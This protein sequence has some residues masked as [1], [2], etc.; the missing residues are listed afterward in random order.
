[1]RRWAIGLLASGLVVLA[2]AYVAHMW[3]RAAPADAPRIEVEIEPGDTL[4]R[5]AARLERAGVVSSGARFRLLA[6]LLG[7]ARP[8]QPGLYEF[9]AGEGWGRVLEKLQRGDVLVLR[10]VIPEGLPS[11]LVHERLMAAPR[12]VGEVEVPPEGSV[13]P[14]TWDYRP[15]ETRAAVLRRMQQGMERTLAELWAKRSPATPVKTPHEAV[16]LASIVEKETARPE[17]RRR[18]AGL[19]ANRLKAGMRLEADPTVIYP[20]TQGRPL[21]RRI[22][23]SEL[24]ADTGWNTYVR[25]GLPRGPITNPGRAALEAVLDPEVHDFLFMVAD[26]T[27]GHAFARTLAEHEANVARWYALRRERGEM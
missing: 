9:R 12:L 8:V 14:A 25:A 16:I 4:A 11:V 13:L 2:G 5:A 23:R 1:M 10:I 15:G 7:G 26:G 22:R 3:R 20:V 27:G 17:E 18:V 24:R 21:G 19:Y 6:R